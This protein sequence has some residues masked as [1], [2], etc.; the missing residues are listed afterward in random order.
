MHC[1]YG[2]GCGKNLGAK[3]VGKGL[4]SEHV[5]GYAQEYAQFMT[6]GA[7]VEQGGFW[8]GVDEDVQVAVIRIQTVQY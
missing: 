2:L 3:A 1:S 5:D 7:D 6:D 4:G 8:S